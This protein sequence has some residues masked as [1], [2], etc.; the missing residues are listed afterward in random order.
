MCQH[1]VKR[2]PKPS[3]FRGPAFDGLIGGDAVETLYLTLQVLRKW[4]TPNS[5]ARQPFMIDS[6]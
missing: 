3:Q 2:K 5:V 6:H 1:R 4:I